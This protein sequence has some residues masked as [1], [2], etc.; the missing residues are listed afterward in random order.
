MCGLC[1][2]MC[3]YMCAFSCGGQGLASRV[4][5][6]C[7]HLIFSDRLPHS[8]GEL[9]FGLDWLASD[10]SGP[11]LLWLW[12]TEMRCYTCL[13]EGVDPH[14]FTLRPS[15]QSHSNVLHLIGAYGL[16][17]LYDWTCG[18]ISL[19]ISLLTCIAA[20]FLKFILTPCALVF[21]PVCES[22]WN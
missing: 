21:F 22:V 19:I 13:Y 6:D 2:Y 1:V 16:K 5:L 12:L 3:T 4:F 20:F 17:V 7:S 18:L 8:T 11:P 15:P 10:P 14:H 9:M